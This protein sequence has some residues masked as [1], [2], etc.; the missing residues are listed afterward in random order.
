MARLTKNQAESLWG[1]LADRFLQAEDILKEIIHRKA[2][3]PI[4][5]STFAEAWQATMRDITLASELRPHVV[6]QLLAEGVGTDEVARNVKGIGTESAESLERQRNNGVPAGHAVVSRHLRKN[7]SR[8][9]TL[10]ITVGPTMMAEYNRIAKR[11]GL[12]AEDI[13]KEAVAKRFAELV[14]ATRRG[15]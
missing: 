3:E 8:P 7:P 14:S 6:Y 4:G 5:H 11:L 9:D 15:R 13:A 10:H 2:W 1:S 12:T